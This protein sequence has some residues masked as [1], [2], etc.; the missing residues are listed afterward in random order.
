MDRKIEF[1]YNSVKYA[2]TEQEIEAAY[3]YQEHQYRLQ[4]A[5]RHLN[6]LAFGLCDDESGFDVPAYD[7]QKNYFAEIYGIS[8]D[9]AMTDDM[10]EAYLDQFEDDFDCNTDENSLWEDAIRAV[11]KALKEP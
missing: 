5:K 9:Q 11:L 2:M 7:E 3:R 8:Y 1:E 10:L 6:I 4:D